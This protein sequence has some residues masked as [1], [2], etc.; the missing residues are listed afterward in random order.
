[1]FWI[2]SGHDSSGYD[3]SR[4]VKGHQN[5]GSLSLSFVISRPAGAPRAEK[6][7][8]RRE[9]VAQALLPVRLGESA[10]RK[11]PALAARFLRT[12]RARWRSEERRVGKECRSRWSPYH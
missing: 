9:R 8:C 3:F 10:Q 11:L 5:L 6:S 4:A 2:L 1:M 7:L 12:G